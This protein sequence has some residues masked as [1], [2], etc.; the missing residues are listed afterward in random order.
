VR[1]LLRAAGVCALLYLPW[2]LF[3]WAYYGSPV[4]QTVVAKGI[5]YAARPG[6]E[7]LAEIVEILQKS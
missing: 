4:P 3:A 5:G 7:A 6:V 1:A 2:F